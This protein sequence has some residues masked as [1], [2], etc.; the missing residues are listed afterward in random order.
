MKKEKNKE[1]VEHSI[2]ELAEITYWF[3]SCTCDGK[4]TE[5]NPAFYFP[6]SALV[7]DPRSVRKN[8]EA[9]EDDNERASGSDYSLD[10]APELKGINEKYMRMTIVEQMLSIGSKSEPSL[11]YTKEQKNANEQIIGRYDFGRR[12][13]TRLLI[14]NVMLFFT[15]TSAGSPDLLRKETERGK[16]TI[17]NSDTIFQK[18]YNIVADYTLYPILDEYVLSVSTMFRFKPKFS[19]IFVKFKK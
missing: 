1:I 12:I 8:M 3:N 6:H 17:L 14:Q 19:D 4:S 11:F 5:W 7:I 16:A 9:S 15:L 18:V 2:F 10:T 13:F